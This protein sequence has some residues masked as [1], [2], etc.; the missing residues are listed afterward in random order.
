MLAGEIFVSNLKLKL[1]LTN[2]TIFF[3]AA[4][5]GAK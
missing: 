4:M 3:K 2:L 1:K 5:F